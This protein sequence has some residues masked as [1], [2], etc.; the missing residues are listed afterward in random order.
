[1]KGLKPTKYRL[2]LWFNTETRK[3]EYGIQAKINNRWTHCSED[4]EPL[5]FPDKADATS[6][7]TEL[8]NGDP[9][10]K[11]KLPRVV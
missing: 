2:H 11:L 10:G 3:E 4:G 5:I 7:M 8:S 1:M 9:S 6:K